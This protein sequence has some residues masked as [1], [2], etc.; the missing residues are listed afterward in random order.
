[1]T[2]ALETGQEAAETLA[3]FLEAVGRANLAGWNFDPAN[4]ILYGS[5][6][7]INAA[8][9][10]GSWIGTCMRRMR[11]GYCRGRKSR[12]GRAVEVP[13]GTGDGRLAELVSTFGAWGIGGCWRSSARGRMRGKSIALGVSCLKECGW[14]VGTDCRR[15]DRTTVAR[16]RTCGAVM[17]YS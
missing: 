17:D 1:M 4:L 15:S 11:G 14:R 6:D 3:D 2:L 16:R 13:V 10:L 5:G 12:R 8:V 9:R 7:P